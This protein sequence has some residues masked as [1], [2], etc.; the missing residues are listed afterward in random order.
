MCILGDSQYKE[1]SCYLYDIL[2]WGRDWEKYINRLRVV[3][4]RL[5]KT[6]GVVLSPSK[7]ILEL[8]KL[9]TWVM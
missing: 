8:D 7:R 9:N 1:A 6:A 2:I 5:I 3:Q 4:T